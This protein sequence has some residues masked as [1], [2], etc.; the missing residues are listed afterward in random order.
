MIAFG[1]D[2]VIA[3]DLVLR[4]LR[5]C[6]S[7]VVVNSAEQH[8]RS[9]RQSISESF[10]EGCSSSPKPHI[11]GACSGIGE[12]RAYDTVEELI[13]HTRS[14]VVNTNNSSEASLFIFQG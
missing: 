11:D 4:D 13:L 12:R 1:H 9:L 7:D 5:R 10:S 3:E 2:I 8:P 6:S 14:E